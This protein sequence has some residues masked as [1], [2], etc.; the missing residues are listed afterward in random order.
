[1][2]RVLLAQKSALLRGALT[3]VLSN[4]S[5]LQVVAELARAND[6]VRMARR[7]QVDVAVLGHDLPGTSTIVGLCEELDCAVLVTLD[8]R[9]VGAVGGELAKLVPRVGMVA[10]EASPGTLVDAVRRLA[11]GEAV[12]DS[13]IAVA[14]LTARG[15]PLTEREREVLRLAR[16]GVPPREIAERLFLSAGTVRNYL[17]RIVTKTGARTRLEA[18]NIAHEAGW[19]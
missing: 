5:D 4:E 17:A 3:G 8:R 16:D 15:N 18:I 12:L 1:M 7:E 2:I 11:R 9:A 13:E 6:V 19:I 14:A 10:T